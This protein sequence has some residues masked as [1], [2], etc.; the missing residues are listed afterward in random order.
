LVSS[1]AV[2]TLANP[3]IVA[4]INSIAVGVQPINIYDLQTIFLNAISSLVS[5]AYIS[6]INVSVFIGGTQILP[7]TGTGVIYGDSE[8][9]FQTTTG[10]VVITKL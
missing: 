6:V 4:Y 7:V 1:T 2:A 5:P 8:G 9:Y 3:A 10:Q